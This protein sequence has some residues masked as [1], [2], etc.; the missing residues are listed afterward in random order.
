MENQE[1][2][3]HGKDI[4]NPDKKVLYEQRAQEYV[5]KYGIIN[6]RIEKTFLVFNVS[7]PQYLGNP[8]YTIQH[9][10]NLETMQETTHQLKR[11]DPKGAYNR[12]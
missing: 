3:K 2:R 9:R 12:G 4:I 11:Y 7:Y 8:R 5:E 6:Y 1:Q 10:V